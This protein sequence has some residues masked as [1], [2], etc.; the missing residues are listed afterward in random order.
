MR[1][2]F[3][4]QIRSLFALFKKS[5]GALA[6]V[7]TRRDRRKTSSP[8][9]RLPKSRL[10]VALPAAA[11]LASRNN[12]A[13]LVGLFSTLLKL[14]PDGFDLAFHAPPLCTSPHA[15]HSSTVGEPN[16]DGLVGYWF[17]VIDYGRFGGYSIAIELEGSHFYPALRILGS[18]LRKG[19][20]RFGP[21]WAHS[22]LK[23]PTDPWRRSQTIPTAPSSAPLLVSFKSGAGRA[24]RCRGRIRRWCGRWRIC[25]CGRC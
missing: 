20:G 13:Q 4:R 18:Q 17:R 12:L 2:S 10:P 22:S 1:A 19:Q 3:A 5:S 16:A 21:N 23:K 24:S 6:I 11:R 8:P 14:P 15:Q 7:P 25:P 9:Q